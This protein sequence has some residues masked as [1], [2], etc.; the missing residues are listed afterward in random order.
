M[1]GC[2]PRMI[3]VRQCPACRIVRARLMLRHLVRRTI[4]CPKPL[5]QRLYTIGQ[6]TTEVVPTLRYPSATREI[7]SSMETWGLRWLNYL[8]V[9]PL[10]IFVAVRRGSTQQHTK[11]TRA[12]YISDTVDRAVTGQTTKC[13]QAQPYALSR[14][15]PMSTQA[16]YRHCTSQADWRRKCAMTLSHFH[17]TNRKGLQTSYDS[18]TATVAVVGIGYGVSKYKEFREQQEYYNAEVAAASR[19]QSEVMMDAYADRSS[20]AELEAAVKAYETHRKS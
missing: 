12:T 3:L 4:R 8:C 16:I 10:F 15:S 13:L 11:P 2:T 5:Y 18:A 9:A 17:H 14:P 7:H 19:R 6:A 1:T 20:L